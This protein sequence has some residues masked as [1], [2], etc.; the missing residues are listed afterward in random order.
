MYIFNFH[1]YVLSDWNEY[2]FSDAF[3]NE[4]YSNSFI[5]VL[6]PFCRPTTSKVFGNGVN[7]TIAVL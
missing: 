2:P 6:N 3:V 5:T 1:S 7:S 4:A